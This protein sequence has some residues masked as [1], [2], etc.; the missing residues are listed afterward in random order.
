MTDR[1]DL[2]ARVVIV[3][4]LTEY[5]LTNPPNENMMLDEREGGLYIYSNINVRETFL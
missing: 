5:R 1:E 3:D 2:N 4:L